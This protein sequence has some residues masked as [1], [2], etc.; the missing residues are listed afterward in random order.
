MANRGHE[1]A[2]ADKTKENPNSFKSKIRE[3][4]TTRD[5]IGPLRNPRD[6]SMCGAAG[7]EQGPQGRFLL[8]FFH[9]ETHEDYGTLDS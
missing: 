8:D 9:G 2:L 5:T 4:R 7:D 6:H 3:K 1:I